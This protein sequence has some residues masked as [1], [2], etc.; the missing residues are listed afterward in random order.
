[1]K[2]AVNVSLPN[3]KN[4]MAPAYQMKFL[5]ANSST[6]IKGEEKTINPQFGIRNYITEKGKISDVSF[7]K[8]IL[9]EEL[10]D[11]IDANFHNSMEGLKYDFIVKP[12]GNPGQIK[13]ELNGV[14]KLK[15]NAKGELEFLTSHGKLLKG[16]PYT[17]QIIKGKKHTIKSKYKVENTTLSFEL[18]AYDESYP[19]IIDPIALKYATVLG[20]GE[21]HYHIT[22]S[23]LDASGSKI[24][25]VATVD[26]LI[27]DVARQLVNIGCMNA[28]GTGVLW[29]TTLYGIGTK[30]DNTYNYGLDIQ[31]N[32]TGDVFFTFESQY[33]GSVGLN[34]SALI[35]GPHP[36]FPANPALGDPTDDGY[37]L[38]RLSA[39]GSTLKYFTYIGATEE[40]GY[41]TNLIVD[42]DIVTVAQEIDDFDAEYLNVIPPTVGAI[43][44]I[45]NSSGSTNDGS[46]IFR[47]NTAVAG[48]NSL[49]KA[50]YFGNLVVTRLKK[51]NNGNIIIVGR[52]NKNQSA[53][54]QPEWSAN[55]ILK[56]GDINDNSRLPFLMKTDY[57]LSTILY[58]TP[59]AVTHPEISNF[60]F[61]YLDINVDI[62]KENNI[63]IGV[64]SAINGNSTNIDLSL[65]N[66]SALKT[67]YFGALVD[68]V[69]PVSSFAYVCFLHKI[70]GN[71]LNTPA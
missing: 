40:H 45:V 8:E 61:Q 13:V 36:V 39:D 15:V 50:A 43:N 42:G 33:A 23:T 37:V 68:Q 14:E 7:F 32:N 67:N 44:T 27:T 12:G 62:D 35:L 59:L 2:G 22:T 18:E 24:Y 54:Y 29:T 4:E 63:I 31:V 26:S 9:Y 30:D 58:A 52:F 1:L 55:S 34:K 66:S 64:Q 19:L 3:L 71:S 6:S 70:P 53:S 20:N 28:D 46:A 47:Y 10:W 49:E 21:V 11:R 17:Y 60:T 38:G 51:D 65:F 5:G 48:Q 25:F 69:L 57:A 16:S 56:Y 41:L